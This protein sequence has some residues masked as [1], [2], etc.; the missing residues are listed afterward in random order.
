[1][2]IPGIVSGSF[3]ALFTV[4]FWNCVY[5]MRAMTEERHLLQDPDYHAYCKKVPYRFVPGI[6]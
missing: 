4:L 1:M 2:T 3:G 6:F 5:F